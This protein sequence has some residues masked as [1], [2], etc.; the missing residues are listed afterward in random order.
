M[1]F[2]IIYRSLICTECSLSHNFEFCRL[3]ALHTLELDI[4]ASCL[5]A[6][7]YFLLKQ[8]FLMARVCHDSTVNYSTL[9]T[10]V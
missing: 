4:R 5:R 6:R 1:I 7:N 10:L 3:S 9:R 8:C 2:F